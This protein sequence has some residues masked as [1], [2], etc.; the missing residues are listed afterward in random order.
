MGVP[1]INKIMKFYGIR[2]PCKMT[3]FQLRYIIVTG[4]HM[5]Y[6]HSTQQFYTSDF[7]QTVNKHGTCSLAEQY[8]QQ[9]NHCNNQQEIF[10]LFPHLDHK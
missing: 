6:L 7:I 3:S 4:R 5:I 8:V 1:V 10:R 2:P 9:I